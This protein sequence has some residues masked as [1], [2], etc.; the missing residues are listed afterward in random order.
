ML[1]VLIMTT[2]H[3]AWSHICCQ[4]IICLCLCIFKKLFLSSTDL[5]VKYV[6]GIINLLVNLEFI[7]ASIECFPI[8]YVKCLIVPVL[9]LLGGSRMI[10]LIL[11]P[12]FVWMG[13][14]WWRNVVAEELKSVLKFSG[15]V[16]LAASALLS[17]WTF[18]KASLVRGPCWPFLCMLSW[19]PLT[20]HSLLVIGM[21]AS[22]ASVS[23]HTSKSVLRCCLCPTFVSK[24]SLIL[25]TTVILSIAPSTWPPLISYFFT[26]IHVH[27]KPA[28]APKWSVCNELIV[29]GSPLVGAAPVIAKSG[30]LHGVQR[31]YACAAHPASTVPSEYKV[32]LLW[33]IAIAI[34]LPPSVG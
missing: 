11:A 17:I 9:F 23:F 26:K 34:A 15:T 21:V 19:W 32:A 12:I 4:A 31:V 30:L 18:Q 16:S 27:S 10:D 22:S 1:Q 5:P 8:N 7:H 14:P 25:L 6:F 13:C 28:R 2:S 24:P 20:C 29:S 33:S 3:G